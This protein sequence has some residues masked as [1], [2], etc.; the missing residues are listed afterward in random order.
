MDVVRKTLEA[1]RAHP[2]QE[3]VYA[4]AMVAGV[5]RELA[6]RILRDPGGEPFAVMCKS[7]GLPR[8]DF[9][10]LVS[11]N[12]PDPKRAD[13]LLAVFDTMARDFSRAVLRYWDWDGNPRIAAITRLLGI[14]NDRE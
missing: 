2:A 3:I 13:G 5:S 9:F 8:D 7:L 14:D 10:A 4:V 11:K 12:E 6:A 1:A